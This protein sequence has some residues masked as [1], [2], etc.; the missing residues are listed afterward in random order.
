M[1]ATDVLDEEVIYEVGEQPTVQNAVRPMSDQKLLHAMSSAESLAT[2]SMER[3]IQAG[4]I[5]NHHGATQM[6]IANAS[7]ANRLGL[8]DTQKSQIV[9]FPSPSNLTIVESSTSEKLVG[10]MGDLIG[11]LVDRVGVT[12]TTNPDLVQ[13]VKPDTQQSGTIPGANLIPQVIG[14]W[15][16]LKQGSSKI[17]WLLALVS[18]LTAGILAWQG[19]PVPSPTPTAITQPTQV[20]PSPSDIEGTIGVTIE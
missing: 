15:P 19:S 5:V 8:S 14:L 13:P 20:L 12:P 7:L 16:W 6:F 18:S 9:P 3:K 17:G 1:A 4:H 10:V 2:K 11:K